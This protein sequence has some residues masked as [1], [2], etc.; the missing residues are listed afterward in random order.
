MKIIIAT[1]NLNKVREIGEILRKSTKSLQILSLIDIFDKVPE[2]PEDARTFTENA[3]LKANWL[4]RKITDSWILA[5]DS[6]L[7]V[8]KLK[9]R[10]GV[11]SARYSGEPVDNKRNIAKVLSEMEGFTDENE[12]DAYFCCS[13]VLVSPKAEK[14]YVAIGKCRGRIAFTERGGGGF[15]YDP[16]FIPDGYDQSFAELPGEIKNSIS[17]RAKALEIL[18]DIF[19]KI[20]KEEN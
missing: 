6:G 14:S 20:V 18:A 3:L 2:I 7:V 19:K 1:T 12:R 15:G 10:P 4:A 11:L 13:M 17:H 16:I 8:E 5:D 9:G